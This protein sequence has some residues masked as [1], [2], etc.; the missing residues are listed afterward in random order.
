VAAWQFYQSR[1]VDTAADR[2]R[3][4]RQVDRLKD[5][6]LMGDLDKAEYWAHRATLH[7][8]L[9]ELPPEGDPESN[10]G[11]RGF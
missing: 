8:E 11:R 9:A 1:A 6:F 10:S 5:L 4:H 2:I 3:I 7:D